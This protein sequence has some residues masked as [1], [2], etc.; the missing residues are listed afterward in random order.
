M[1][2]D[3]RWIE[4]AAGLTLIAAIIFGCWV[5]LRPF[6][7]AILWAAVLC[8]ATWPLRELL[9]Q[10]LHGRRT[11][12]AALMTLAFSL[13]V[14]T[15]FIVIGLTFTQSIQTAIKWIESQL[16]AGLPPPPAWVDRIPRFGHDI[17]NYWLQLNED[18]W[19][20]ISRLKPWLTVGGIWLLDRSFDVAKGIFHLSMSLLIAFFLYRDGEGAVRYVR[21]GL[22]QISG[23][24][25][26]H[27]VDVV[28][29]TIRAVVYGV[30]GTALVQALLAGIGFS[31]AHVPSPLTLALLTFFLGLLPFGSPF[32]WIGSAIW[33]FLTHQI[34]LG[35]FMVVYGLFI[36]NGAD[37]VIR[38]LL[39]SRTSR[40]SFITMF[41]GVLGGLSAFG[42]IGLFL[43]PTLLAVGYALANEILAP[44]TSRPEITP[45]N[46]Q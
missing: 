43:G 7:S 38:P 23:D 37:H 22:R 45:D 10:W 26:P 40:L 16:S 15:P 24:T 42:F 11:L 36:I 34:G 12:V 46:P 20:T 32:V 44:W 25:A 39:M 17:H 33:L 1:V 21:Q 6:V 29:S 35:I 9:M 28:K 30:F 5:V 3:I 4:Q 18:I 13:A 19:P 31:I 2:K 14:L 27:L 41:I 8:A